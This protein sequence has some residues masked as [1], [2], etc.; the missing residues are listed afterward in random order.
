[1]SDQPVCAMCGSSPLVFLGVL[2]QLVW[3]RCRWCGAEQPA[4]KEVS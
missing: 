3:L 1:M 2:G 4:R